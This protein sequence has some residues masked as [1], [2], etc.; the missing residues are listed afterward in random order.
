MGEGEPL[1]LVAGYTR[2]SQNCWDEVLDLLKKHFTLVNFDNRG[3]GRS[4]DNEPILTAKLLAKDTQKLME[5]LG[6]K[7][8]HALGHSMGGTIVQTLAAD[9]PESVDTIIL[10]ATSARW[11]IPM[12]YGLG[13]F[14]TMAE[15]SCDSEDLLRARAAWSYSDG[16]L[17]NEEN[18]ERYKKRALENPFP[19]SIKDQKRQFHVLK[20][21]NGNDQLEKIKAKTL[22]L[23][24]EEDLIS[25]PKEAKHLKESIAFSKL[26][27]FQA[28][29]ALTVE[30]P[31]LLAKEVIE[32]VQS[33]SLS[34]SM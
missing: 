14:L 18:F 12:L 24:G 7:R 22:I 16:Y 13:S 21:F 30:V 8:Y 34:P 3:C 15:A 19:P 2:H 1:A 27:T 20:E 17:Q 28:A 5:G 6:F 32:F 31:D 25:L 4:V 10:S 33:E 23:A 11:R 26:V 9:Y 29:H